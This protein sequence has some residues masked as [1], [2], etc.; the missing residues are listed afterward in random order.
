MP[1]HTI[2]DYDQAKHYSASTIALNGMDDLRALLEKLV[3]RPDQCVVRGKLINGDTAH[4]IRR[5][6]YPKPEDE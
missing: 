6:V 1:D 5:L 4:G 3:R 2:K